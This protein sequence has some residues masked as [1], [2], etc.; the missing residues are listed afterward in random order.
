MRAQDKLQAMQIELA[1]DTS[2]TA[3]E[4]IAAPW[5]PS[6]WAVAQV[7]AG[8]LNSHPILRRCARI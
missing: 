8:L 3:A 5:R 2:L 6:H 4:Q 7:C 1:R